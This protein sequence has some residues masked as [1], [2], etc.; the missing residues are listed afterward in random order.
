MRRAFGRLPVGLALLAVAWT[1][2]LPVPDAEAGKLKVRK[3]P[4][5]WADLRSVPADE[6][7]RAEPIR[8]AGPLAQLRAKLPEAARHSHLQLGERVPSL[9]E[10]KE[11]ETR[12][13]LARGGGGDT[14]VIKVAVIRVEFETDRAGDQTTGDG[15]F[16]RENLDPDIFIDPAPHNE[17]YFAAHI[18]AVSRYWQ[19]MTYGCVRIEGDV[20]PLNEEF[21]AYRLTD[22]ADYGPTS[23]DELFSIEGLT[24]YSRESLIAADAD[25]NLVWSDYDVYFVVHAGSDWQN[26]VLQN[27]PIDLPTFSIAFSDSDVVVTDEGDSLF[28]M[29]TYPETSS[30]DGFNVGLN[31]GIAHDMGHQLGLFDIY[32]VVTFAPTAGF[33]DVMDSGNLTSAF[34]QDP[35]YPAEP[36]SLVE[37]IGVLPSAVGAWSRWLVTFQLGIDPVEIKG[38]FPRAR[39]RAIQ[40]QSA[41]L[42]IGT[43]KWYR[44]S[45][46][47]TEYFLI[48]NRVDDLD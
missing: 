2:V 16:M 13:S 8:R 46:S 45:I 30:Q 26:D 10:R 34:V 36:D 12:G 39:L 29:I 7:T 27:T 5:A 14:T 3:M 24:N 40:D 32:N 18:E 38:D 4:Q 44:L 22:M 23:P 31:G 47:D 35:Q 15:R 28:T 25:S 17:A 37:I 6:M 20:F 21:G 41:S 43:E 1:A 19:A 11:L 48:E 33:Y 42:P 9:F